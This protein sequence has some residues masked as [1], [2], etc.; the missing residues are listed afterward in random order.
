MPGM[1]SAD[2][3]QLSSRQRR[4]IETRHI[5]AGSRRFFGAL[6]AAL[7]L[8]L[9]GHGAV[10][11][12]REMRCADVGC[13]ARAVINTIPDGERIALIP[14]VW[15]VTDLPEHEAQALYDD[16]Y[17]AMYD[18]SDDRHGLVKRD[19]VYDE[20][21]EAT[22]WEVFQSNYQIY[23]DRLRATVVVHCKD[24]GMSKGMLKLSCTAT[25][26]HENS[27]IAREMRPS[28]ALI[29][30]ERSMFPY[31]YALTQL[32][33]SLAADALETGSGR[34]GAQRI[35]AAFIVDT[36]I[37][38][39]TYL[40]VD[41]GKRILENI[42]RQFE[43]F[44]HER[45]R[46]DS[47]SQAIGRQHD[48]TSETPESYELRGDFSWTDE[49][50]ELA[51]LW[52]ELREFGR[53]VAQ[54]RIEL[55]RAW[56]PHG[57]AG[58]RRYDAEAR[59]TPSDSLHEETV[60]QAAMNL[61]RARVVAQAVGVQAPASE[62]VTS[63]AESMAALQTLAYGIPVD[64]QVEAWQDTAGEHHVWLKARVVSV[65]GRIRPSVEAVL[66]KN[67]LKSREKFGITLSTVA[68]VHAGV[69]A[70]GADGGVVRLYPNARVRDLIVP[71]GSG[72]S[73]PRRDDEYRDFWSAP[74]PGHTENHEAII[75]IASI[76][77]LNF[78]SLGASV[79]SDTTETMSTAISD[80][81]FFDALGDLDLS[82]ATVLV[83]PYRVRR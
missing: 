7:A 48:D 11:Q 35:A 47:F 80:S 75:V 41:I 59:A 74:L 17:Q 26:V 10:A 50:R 51:S 43:T 21:W 62:V 76:E 29:P 6:T 81:R 58:T 57:I 54:D 19:R 3:S 79:G 70:W 65:G 14:F 73:L 18:A 78:A 68:A 69:F 60:M 4:A 16:L 8:C 72:V 2:T 64:E 42:S 38:E 28:A 61:A 36:D 33:N 13:L 40:T 32:S 45:Q 46:D 30:I 37:R 77:P 27:A 63:E 44:Q 24:S 23:V 66:T 82:Q 34:S 55:R 71:A 39:Q 52:V 22:K 67:D 12:D 25:G 31:E 1:N 9:A 83:L 5:A 20:V 56:L 15:P 53:T 49:R